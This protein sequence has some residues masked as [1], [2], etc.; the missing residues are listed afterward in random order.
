MQLWLVIMHLKLHILH[1]LF[2][3]ISMTRNKA[4]MGKAWF[5]VIEN[6]NYLF[7][8]MTIHFRPFFKP[9]FSQLLCFD[10][11]NEVIS[12]WKYLQTIVSVLGFFT[13]LIFLFFFF[14][15]HVEHEPCYDHWE[16]EVGTWICLTGKL[17][18]CNGL[19]PGSSWPN[20]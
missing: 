12:I 20:E 14:Q 10:M 1:G 7:L 6:I 18:L 5:L 19:L 13:S 15:P 9:V 3:R 2:G 16:C 8:C 17:W 11:L 4:V